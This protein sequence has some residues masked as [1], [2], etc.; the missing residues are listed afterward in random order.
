M[1]TQVLQASA[2]AVARAA[3]LLK[4]DDIVAFPTET[5]YGLAARATSPSAVKKIFAA[6]GRPSDNPLIVHVASWEMIP[7]VVS[8]WNDTAEALARAF[9]PGPLTL[10]LPKNANICNEASAD[11]QTIGVRWPNHPVALQLIQ[12]ANDPLA[13]PSAN[14]SGNPSATTAQHVQHDLSGKIP[15][16]LD[17]GACSIGVESTVVDLSQETP[18]ILRP[19]HITQ[20]EL[21]DVCGCSVL[22]A[23]RHDQTPKSPGMKYKHYAP[24]TPI[25]ILNTRQAIQEQRTTSSFVLTSSSHAKDLQ[26]RILAPNTLYS[27]LREADEKRSDKIL[28]LETDDLHMQKD[29]WDRLTR[30]AE[31]EPNEATP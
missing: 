22:L 21:S 18:V 30:A 13:A 9:W 3:E 2:E 11:L 17:G 15:L 26:A 23:S 19:G 12:A 5:V 27:L 14:L 24:K 4:Q 6:K 16:I 7:K 25:F 8:S 20:Q 1:E 29:L 10:V 28:V 31:Q